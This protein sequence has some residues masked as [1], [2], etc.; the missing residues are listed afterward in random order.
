MLYQLTQLSIDTDGRYATDAELQFLEDYLESAET[1]I[2]AYEKI[3][4]SEETWLHHLTMRVRGL[5]PQQIL[6]QRGNYDMTGIWER[7]MRMLM[8][9]TTAAMLI[10]DLDR[11]REGTLIWHQTI[12][13]AQKVQKITHETFGLLAEIIG[14][15]LTPEETKC[16]VPALQLDQAIL[17]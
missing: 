5:N 4:D 1:R 16:I 10:N 8:Y 9:C 3:R 2:S 11:L 7:D 6:F 15:Y 12:T 13:K 14:Q 17:G